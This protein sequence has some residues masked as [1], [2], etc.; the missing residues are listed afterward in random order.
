MTDN[1]QQ[2]LTTTETWLEWKRACTIGKCSEETGRQL[3]RFAQRRLCRVLAKRGELGLL[4]YFDQPNSNAA[5]VEVEKHLYAGKSKAE[6][7]VA[8]KRY[9][10]RLLKMCSESR[11]HFESVVSVIIQH[12]VLRKILHE[13]KP[14]IWNASG[15]P[16]RDDG[17]P[18]RVDSL[19]APIDPSQGDAS[20]YEFLAGE[21]AGSV[22]DIVLE[23][24]S[25][26]DADAI[27]EFVS[28]EMVRNW[29]GELNPRTQQIIACC[30]AGKT[31]KEMLDSN[32]FQCQKSQMYQAIE[33]TYANI[34]NISW[35]SAINPRAR[36]FLTGVF[37]MKL[38]YLIVEYLDQPENEALRCFISKELRS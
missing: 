37:L 18:R 26:A 17:Q 6:D 30:M 31:V 22:E 21:G 1:P 34:K 27:Q 19:D 13:E 11:S 24:A 7:N 10:D 12:D 15:L 36:V 8:G 16:Q 14:D 29:W 38:K 5:W 25:D 4:A 23:P 35:G 33:T 9:K 20:L 32:L 3:A 28:D 2:P